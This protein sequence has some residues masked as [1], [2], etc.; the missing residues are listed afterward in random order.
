MDAEQDDELYRRYLLSM[1][2]R[3]GGVVPIQGVNFDLNHADLD[4]SEWEPLDVLGEYIAAGFQPHI[5]FPWT[6]AS[7]R[8]WLA[9][10]G[11]FVTA[12]PGD[13]VVVTS[14]ESVQAPK[15]ALGKLDHPHH[16]ERRIV[17]VSI[18]RASDASLVPVPGP[19]FFVGTADVITPI[20]LNDPDGARR[21]LFTRFE[22]M[23]GLED[24]L[25]NVEDYGMPAWTDQFADSPDEV[26]FAAEMLW[27]AEVDEFPNAA[28]MAFGYLVGRAE[29]R[30]GRRAQARSASSGLRKTGDP[31]RRAA[32]AIIDASPRILLRRCAEKVAAQLDK[33]VRS[34]EATI[35]VLFSEDEEGRQRPDQ[36]KIVEYLSRQP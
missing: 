29:A 2:C 3:H 7:A 21:A 35:A 36:A 26:R 13:K 11:R 9:R 24:L 23:S 6:N 34:I 27:K 14:I 30:D 18:E 8:E 19:W 20:A 4:R 5:A 1:A 25:D 15:P 28:A 32:I 16:L 12:E 22:R 33:S 31:A 10:H 17:R